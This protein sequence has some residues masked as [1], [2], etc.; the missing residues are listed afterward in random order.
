MNEQ[1]LIDTK[2]HNFERKTYETEMDDFNLRR[3]STNPFQ[4]RVSQKPG[5]LFG[6]VLF[7]L[8][9]SKNG[10]AYAPETLA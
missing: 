1:K 4:G 5:K 7:S 9:V 2:Q 8:S 3:C 10:E 6:P